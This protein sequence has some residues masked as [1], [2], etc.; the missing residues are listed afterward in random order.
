MAEPPSSNG[1]L[2]PELGPLRRVLVVA[3]PAT[4]RNVDAVMVALREAAPA[5]VSLEILLTDGP[6]AAVAITERAADGADVVVAVG[7]DGTVAD[8]ATGLRGR[9][10]PL[11]IVPA[12]STNIIARELGWPADPAAAAA[13]LFGPNRLRSMDVGRCGDRVFLH[14][15]GAGIDSRLFAAANPIWKRRVGWLAY[16]PPAGASLR[17]PAARFTIIAD[18]ATLEI[19][20]PLVLVANGGSIIDPRLTL[21]P[22]LRSDDGW[23]DVLVFTATRPLPIARTLA[24]LVSRGLH[25]SPFVH[26]LRAKRVE[27]SADPPL[28]IQ[29]DGD[30]AGFTPA[31]FAVSPGALTVV[32]PAAGSDRLESDRT[33]GTAAAGA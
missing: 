20:S 31:A 24:R 10:I 12:G 25:L 3:N 30:V 29:L 26:H 17:Q 16:L 11:A 22:D 6:G 23:L 9:P 8:V 5:G 4:R 21:Y 1:V 27:M 18:A 19:V 13:V 28:P 7:G 14:M 32:V 33:T 2:A 15:A